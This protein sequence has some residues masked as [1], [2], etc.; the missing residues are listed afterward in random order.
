MILRRLLPA[1]LLLAAPVAMAAADRALLQAEDSPDGRYRLEQRA[2]FSGSREQRIVLVHQS[3]GAQRDIYAFRGLATVQ[4]SPD[5]THL[6]INDDADGASAQCHVL[7]LSDFTMMPLHD[8]MWRAL[9]PQAAQAER[10]SQTYRCASWQAADRIVMHE[11]GRFGGRSTV[12]TVTWRLA[13]NATASDMM[14]TCDGT[15]TPA[16]PPLNATYASLRRRLSGA[17]WQPHVTRDADGVKADEG[18]PLELSPLER[19]F[20]SH[21]MREIDICAATGSPCS[22]SFS[23]RRGNRLTVITQGEDWKSARIHDTRITCAAKPAR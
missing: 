23:D 18:K 13:F 21:G 2:A 4:W 6:F 10:Y 5:A 8:V 9:H 17:D 7:R 1:L 14:K 20:W 16:A 12:R 15:A 22:F 3:S 11:S 19:D